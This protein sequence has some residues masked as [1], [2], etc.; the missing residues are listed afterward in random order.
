MQDNWFTW[1]FMIEFVNNNAILSSIEQSTFFLNKS[2]HSHMSFDLNSI[3]Y[4]ITWARIEAGK[5]EN[6]FKHMKWS[7]TLIKQVLTRV[8]VT[9]K[10]QI[11]KHWKKMIYKI[12][13]IMIS[14]SSKKLDNKMLKLFKILIK[15]EHAYQLKLSLTMKIH[16]EFASN[17]LRLDSKNSLNEQWNESSDFIVIDDK[18]EWKVKNILNFRH[19]ERDKRLQYH[20]NWKEYDVNLHWYNVDESEFEECSK[21][22]NDF[23]EWYSNKSR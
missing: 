19:Y 8:R 18:D 12:N 13:D 23:H 9:M 7:L 2:F 17:L 6:I 10:K 22:V 20:V 21:I 16:S 5:A 11:D 14:W 3:E 1:L 15:I 4:E